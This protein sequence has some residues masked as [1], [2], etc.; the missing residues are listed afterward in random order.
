MTE[1]PDTV[2]RTFNSRRASRVVGP[3]A[4]DRDV[5]PAKSHGGTPGDR[6]REFLREGFGA[7]LRALRVSA[8]LTQ[9][10]LGKRAKVDRVHISRLE[11]GRR[12]PE[13]GTV[14]RLVAQLV[15]PTEREAQRRH[16]NRLADMSWREWRRK[17]TALRGR[18]IP[19]TRS[20]VVAEV[21]R[22]MNRVEALRG[23]VDR[24]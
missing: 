12:R 7:H 6:E 11:L 22:L 15:P 2:H 14:R 19:V 23:M 4:G 24:S 21:D 8:G 13:G 18:P 9:A 10:E 5:L 20:E 1:R 16:L 17:Q 3:Q